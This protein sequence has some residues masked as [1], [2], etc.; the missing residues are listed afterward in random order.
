VSSANV[1]IV[2]GGEGRRFGGTVPKQFASLRGEPLLVWS[3]RAFAAVRS[4]TRMIVVAAPDEFARCEG[5]LAP[6]GL[7]VKLAPAGAERQDSV[8]AGIE[9]LEPTCDVVLVHDAVRPLVTTA[10]IV[11]CVAA[12]EARG[13]AIL[14]TPVN[15]TVKRCADGRIV[16]TVPRAD[17]WLA[18]TPQAFR[19]ADLRRVHAEAARQGVLATDDA[20]LFEW[21]G[22]P[23]AIVPGDGRNRKITTPED[24]AWAEAVLGGS[25][26]DQD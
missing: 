25:G 20:S 21:A 11:A 23:V 13:A 12:A 4:L 19:A 15:D 6:L 2:A 24:L 1:I 7:A 17:L 22:L 3:V 10:S 26:G 16:A 18:Q 5:L 8:R 14:A 9:L